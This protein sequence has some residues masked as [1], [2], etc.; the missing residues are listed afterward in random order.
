MEKAGRDSRFFYL[1]WATGIELLVTNL[2]K[3]FCQYC[4]LKIRH[5]CTNEQPQECWDC[6][7]VFL[8]AVIFL[9]GMQLIK[10]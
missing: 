5:E 8:W 3:T 10:K 2:R 1:W 7:N 6:L 4:G 9:S